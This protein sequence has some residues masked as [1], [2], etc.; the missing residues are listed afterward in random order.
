MVCKNVVVF[1]DYWGENK[2]RIKNG[3]TYF[4]MPPPKKELVKFVITQR[5]T[6]VS[7]LKRLGANVS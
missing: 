1:L 3:Y 6:E 5:T 7:Q 2:Q 4:D